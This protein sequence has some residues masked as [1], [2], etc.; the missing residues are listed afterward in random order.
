MT[1]RIHPTAV[2]GPQVELGED[3]IVGPFCVLQGPVK[4][5][6]RNFFASHVNIGGAAE[7]HGH[8]Y[9]PSWDEESEEGGVVIGSDNIFKEF[10]T[11]N[12]GWQSQTAIGDAGM[13]MGK[14]H[15]GHD[16]QIGDRVTISC[17]V[18]V[19]GHTVVEDDATIGLGAALHQ[20]L[21]IGAGSMIGMQAAVTRNLPPFTVAM[22]APATPKR[23]N[24][25]RLDRLGVAHEQHDLLASV[26]LGQNR[27][28]AG[29]DDVV[30]RPVD[31]WL[32]RT[33][34]V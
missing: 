26:V 14:M 3:N 5:G 8:L 19:G 33:P 30:R 22:G 31:A 15:F 34:A 27:D 11:L 32:N 1:N 21:T 20:H 16:A 24:T 13:F 28:A 12:T 29:L 10:V 23:L 4:V 18:L 7:V 17:A 25:Q 2:I 9:V 6:N